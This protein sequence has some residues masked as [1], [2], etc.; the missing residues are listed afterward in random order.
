MQDA[1]LC[2]SRAFM[3]IVGSPFQA[4]DHHQPFLSGPHIDIDT[5]TRGGRSQFLI[6]SRSQT[7]PTQIQL[8]FLHQ[9]LLSCTLLSPE[10]VPETTQKVTG[11]PSCWY[12]NTQNSNQITNILTNFSISIQF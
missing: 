11:L 1:P 5:R 6:L 2:V 4:E 9:T 7:A 8:L 10:A 3:M 12:Y